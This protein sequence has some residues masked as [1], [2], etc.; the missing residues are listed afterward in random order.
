MID[1]VFLCNDLSLIVFVGLPCTDLYEGIV[2]IA[3]VDHQEEVAF[4]L[5]AVCMPVLLKCDTVDVIYLGCWTTSMSS[6]F[7]LM[8]FV[9]LNTLLSFRRYSCFVCLI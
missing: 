3:E 8:N 7:T 4:V 6:N 9:D 5:I 2:G 1:I